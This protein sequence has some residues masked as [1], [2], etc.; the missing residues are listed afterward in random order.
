MNN[1]LVELDSLD[2]ILIGIHQ[3]IYTNDDLFKCLQYNSSDALY[4]TITDEQKEQLRNEGNVEDCRIYLTPFN[5]KII[6]EPRTELRIYHYRFSPVNDYLMDIVIGFDIV[7]HNDLWRLE[8]SKRRPTTIFQLLLK[9]LNGLYLESIGELKL[10]QSPCNLI[11]YN[12]N[13]FTGYSFY[14]KTRSS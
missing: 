9:S 10:V 8:D 6:S 11:Y 4:Q 1:E 12:A 2:N 5:N 14:M 13:G 7:C 3:A